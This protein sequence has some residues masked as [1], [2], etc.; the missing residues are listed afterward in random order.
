MPISRESS[1]AL[2]NAPAHPE[3]VEGPSTQSTRRTEPAE[4][5]S[6]TCHVCGELLIVEIETCNN[7]ER[8]FHLRKREDSTSPDCGE[9]WINEQYLALEFACDICLGKVPDPGKRSEPPIHRQH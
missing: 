5:A 9:V 8:P 6:A 4:A 2:T 7:C 1:S 3:P